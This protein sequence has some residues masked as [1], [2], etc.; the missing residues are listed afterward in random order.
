[1][2]STTNSVIAELKQIRADADDHERKAYT[3]RAAAT[4]TVDTQYARKC[5]LEAREEAGAAYGC[6]L[7]ARAIE[8]P[9]KKSNGDKTDERE[10]FEEIEWHATCALHDAQDADKACIRLKQVYGG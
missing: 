9:E 7:K 6:L 3:A 8:F 2:K 1:M 5:A 4:T 10:V